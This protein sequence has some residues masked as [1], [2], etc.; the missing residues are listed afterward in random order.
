MRESPPVVSILPAPSIRARDATLH[1]G[2]HPDTVHRCQWQ[3]TIPHRAVSSRCAWL[4]DARQDSVRFLSFLPLSAAFLRTPS[5][6][7]KTMVVRYLRCK[8]P[9]KNQWHSIASLQTI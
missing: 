3:S 2:T 9:L 8:V 4:L 7:S 1:P 6:L 5:N